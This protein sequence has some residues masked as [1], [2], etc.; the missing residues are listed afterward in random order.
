MTRL[1]RR[2]F[3]LIAATVEA[4]H[5]TALEREH[6]ARMFATAL[7]PTNGRFDRE[8]FLRACGVPS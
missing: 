5:L 7:Q 8:R 4:L 3:V 6:V 1:T 2:H